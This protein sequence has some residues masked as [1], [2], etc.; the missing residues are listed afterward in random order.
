MKCLTGL[1]CAGVLASVVVS[2]GPA[3]ASRCSDAHSAGRTAIAAAESAESET[4]RLIRDRAPAAQRLRVIDLEISQRMAATTSF[5]EAM[6]YCSFSAKQSD[7]RALDLQARINRNLKRLKEA[8]CQRLGFQA[9]ALVD[10]AATYHKAP[11]ER[12]HAIRDEFYKGHN[13]LKD[14]LTS[15]CPDGRKQLDMQLAKIEHY[16]LTLRPNAAEASSPDAR[17]DE[18]FRK[19]LRLYR[20][21]DYRAAATG[22]RLVAEDGHARAQYYL[23]R[24]HMEGW[25]VRKSDDMALSWFKRSAEQGDPAGQNSLGL[26][27]DLGRGVPEDDAKAV[28]WY[29]RAANQGLPFA[30]TNLGEMYE[31]GQGVRR[32]LNTAVKLYRTAADHGHLRAHYRLGRVYERGLGVKKDLVTAITF[33]RRAADKGYKPAQQALAALGG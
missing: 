26:M 30:Q 9:R 4:R 27:Y 13:K 8:R 3:H 11:P 21:Q 25:G 23:G 31:Q 18:E 15:A 6:D 22:F 14:G 2:G 24:L 19:A 20:K 33:Y 29:A 1:I 16:A 10:V 17:Q 32:D 28:K 7:R 12:R 5:M